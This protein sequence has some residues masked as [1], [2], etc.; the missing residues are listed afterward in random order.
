MEIKVFI[1]EA[2]EHA[3]GKI[4][5]KCNIWKPFSEF[6]IDNQKKSGL[7]SHCKSCKEEYNDNRCRF[8]VW[9]INKRSRVKYNGNKEFTIEPTDIPGVKI[10]RIKGR[11]GRWTWEATE[12]PKVCSKWGIELNWEKTGGSSAVNSP[13]LD[14][15]NPDKGY[16]PGNVRIVCNA[17]N[18]AKGNCPPDVWDILEKQ[19]GRAILFGNEI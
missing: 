19:I 9:F 2:H 14:R 13:S 10:R 15:I 1:K 17:Y 8:K 4:C 16:I 5:T 6:H 3:K 18:M 12:Y 11:N 7:Y